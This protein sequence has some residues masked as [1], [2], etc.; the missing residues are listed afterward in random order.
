MCHAI[1]DS[2][3]TAESLVADHSPSVFLWATACRRFL[4]YGLFFVLYLLPVY[5][6]WF[7]GPRR[8]LTPNSLVGHFLIIGFVVSECLWFLGSNVDLFTLIVRFC[9]RLCRL[10]KAIAKDERL[11]PE[12]ALTVVASPGWTLAAARGADRQ[13]RPGRGACRLRS[14]P[15]RRFAA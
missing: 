5:T 11:A 9:Y 7:G 6:G 14:D 10:D 4:W 13:G 8:L 15:G 12:S 1:E 2:G 3:C